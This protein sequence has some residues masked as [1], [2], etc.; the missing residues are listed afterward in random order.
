[1]SDLLTIYRSQR[2]ARRLFQVLSTAILLLGFSLTLPAQAANKTTRLAI[3]PGDDV[4]LVYAEGMVTMNGKSIDIGALIPDNALIKTGKGAFA[5]IA[6]KTK[7]IVRVGENTVV[8]LSLSSLSRKV[9]LKQ[10]AFTAVLHK[11]DKSAGGGLVLK[12]PLATGGVRG[13]SFCTWVD[14]S[15]RTY[16][17]SCN[18]TVSLQDADLASPFDQA[19]THHNAIWFNKTAKGIVTK[20]AEMLF[21]T[22]KDL[23]TLAARIGD[24]IDWT[25]LEH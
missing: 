18:G 14:P 23:E 8:S 12:T 9:D 11:L 25:T 2:S 3:A 17:C 15:G 21:H 7:N 4:Q 16:F 20:P 24:S 19:G 6:F 13:T 22:D 1:M 5:E 10:G